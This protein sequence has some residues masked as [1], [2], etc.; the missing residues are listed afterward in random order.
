MA[1][2]HRNRHTGQTGAGSARPRPYHGHHPSPSPFFPMKSFP[3]PDTIATD[4]APSHDE[5]AQCA[6]ELWTRSERPEGR[7]D[8]IWLEAERRLISARRTPD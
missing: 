2:G 5:I 4:L 6:R 1:P 8:V 7:D 3:A